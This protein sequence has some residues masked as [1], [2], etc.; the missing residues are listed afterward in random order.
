MSPGEITEA[1]KLWETLSK[2]FGASAVPFIAAVWIYMQTR[3]TGP[4]E[5]SNPLAELQIELRA[6]RS[7]MSEVKER[8]AKI[9]GGLGL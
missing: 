9:E 3:K 1:V 7:D 6:I 5:T 8:V 2:V 4:R